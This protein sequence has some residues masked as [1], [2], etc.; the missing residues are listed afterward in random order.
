MAEKKNDWQNPLAKTDSTQ[1]LNWSKTGEPSE[2]PAAP[3]TWK[4]AQPE[5]AQPA[6][7]WPDDNSDLDEGRITANG[8]GLTVGE[9][10]ALD[11]IGEVHDL[12]RN[13]ILRFAV[14]RLILDWR[15]GRLDLAELT[16]R[17]KRRREPKNRLE[18]PRE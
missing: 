13:A 3:A 5:P 8:V 18:M 10:D 6:R 15:A 1:S 2:P 17:K 9:L 16:K 12:A 14:R 11:H 4:P 7:Y